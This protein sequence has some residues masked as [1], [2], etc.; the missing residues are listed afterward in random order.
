MILLFSC[1]T[2]VP[3]ADHLVGPFTSGRSSFRLSPAYDHGTRL[4]PLS[5]NP[6][7]FRGSPSAAHYDVYHAAGR[8][9]KVVV[10]LMATYGVPLSL[11]YWNS[12]LSIL[13]IEN[14]HA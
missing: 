13:E 8:H 2:S 9:R 1:A 14:D 3:K 11:C 12:F 7:R 5:L 10:F 6:H 4:K